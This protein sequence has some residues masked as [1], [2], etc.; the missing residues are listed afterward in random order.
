MCS[1]ALCI[2][3]YNTAWS[4]PALFASIK[5]QAI[6]FDEILMYN[7]CSEDETAFLAKAFGATVIEGDVNRG[8]SHGKNQLANYAKSDWLYFLDADDL[9]L[10]NFSEVAINW[11]KNPAAPDVVLMGYNYVNNETG[12][13]M[14]TSGYNERYLQE[15]PLRFMI[16]N[17]VVNSS[18]IKKDTFIAVG[19]F[20]LDPLILYTEDRAF[21]VRLALAKATFE[22]EP[23]VCVQINYFPGSMS[24]YKP[25]QWIEAGINLWEKTF[26]KA[27]HAY[28]AELVAQLFEFA[29]WAAK[30]NCW[31]LVKRSLALARLID[32]SIKPTSSSWFLA[33][34]R[35]HSFG[36]FFIREYLLRIMRFARYSGKAAPPL[37]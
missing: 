9:L 6:P 3:A 37:P 35:I 22:I 11:A 36:A 34:F 23:A 27:G 12:E 16:S 26:Q 32:H 33:A 25:Q 13:V 21:S 8:C 14:A 2:P 28:S 29:I 18:L 17:K 31:R 5:S 15:D 1:I 19:G 30:Y 10:P 24:A 4:L 7:D 20:D